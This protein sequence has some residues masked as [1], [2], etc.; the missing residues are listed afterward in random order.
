MFCILLLRSVP[1]LF[2]VEPFSLQNFIEEDE[3]LAKVPTLTIRKLLEARL[4]MGKEQID[5]FMNQL[6][7]G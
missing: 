7:N 4:D 2:I 1:N 6:K 5:S 3:H